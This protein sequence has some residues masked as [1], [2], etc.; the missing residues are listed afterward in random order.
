MAQI[1]FDGQRPG[2]KV[3]FVFRRHPIVMW[4]GMLILVICVGLGIL[5]LVIWQGAGGTLWAMVALW[6]AGLMMFGYT[7][8][9]WHFSAYIVTD[10]R[11]R[12]MMQKGIFRQ[13][14]TDL[15]LDKVETVTV[16]TSGLVSSVLNYGTI[17]I[18]T[19]VGDLTISNVGRP[20]SVYNKLQDAVGKCKV[21]K[22]E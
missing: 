9:L 17:L 15:G 18:Q 16:D 6:A 3:I 4:R 1:E 13:K 14:V 2:E 20:K 21:Q 7:Y 5:P 11:L 19:V 8:V 22:D 12:V 10:Q